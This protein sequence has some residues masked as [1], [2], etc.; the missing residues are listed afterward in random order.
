MR[1]W[2]DHLNNRTLKAHAREALNFGTESPYKNAFL[3][4]SGSELGQSIDQIPEME[5]LA[6]NWDFD[7]VRSDKY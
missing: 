5:T 2:I 6:L 7:T 4:Q 3:A 1:A